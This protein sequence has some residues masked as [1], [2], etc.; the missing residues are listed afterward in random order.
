LQDLDVLEEARSELDE[1]FEAVWDAFTGAVPLPGKPSFE[2]GG[3]TWSGYADSGGR[4]LSF[5][6]PGVSFQ[7]GVCDAYMSAAPRVFGVWLWCTKAVKTRIE[8]TPG[9]LPKVLAVA[10]AR[11]LRLAL[12]EPESLCDADVPVR[13]ED[14][15]APGLALAT[16]LR[17]FADHAIAL[18]APLDALTVT[19]SDEA[20]TT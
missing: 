4:C 15:A 12:E 7:L 16:M 17:A 20:I 19:S 2:H 9:A 5:S 11:G 6:T 13:G 14:P 8:K 10:T 18:Q 3:R 1:Y